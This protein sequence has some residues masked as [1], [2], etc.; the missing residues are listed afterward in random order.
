M[1]PYSNDLRRKLVEAYESGGY[2]QDELA[3]LFGVCPATLRNF[4][5]RKRETG[6]PDALPHAGGRAAALDAADHDRLRRLVKGHD[7]ATL[8]ELCR[9]V[10]RELKKSISASAL[11]RLLQALGLPRKKSR[12]T[13]P[14]ET[15]RGSSARGLTT[16]G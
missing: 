4:I 15:R 13:P 16:G 1:N 7:D 3:E 9:M 5:R 11:C 6:S 12:S 2:S 10:E 14:S 8:A